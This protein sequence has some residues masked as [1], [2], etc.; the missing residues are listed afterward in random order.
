MQNDVFDIDSPGLGTATGDVFVY[1]YA[2][3]EATGI[4][5]ISIFKIQGAGSLQG[6]DAVLK[7][8]SRASTTRTSTIPTPTS[9][10]WLKNP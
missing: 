5:D 9:S 2:L 8:L 3:G 4:N 7:H 10:S 6:S 1:N